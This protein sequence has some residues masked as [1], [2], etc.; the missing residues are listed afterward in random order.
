MNP[1]FSIVDRDGEKSLWVNDQNIWDLSEKELT[2]DVKKAI[3]NAY[4]IGASHMSKL[5]ASQYI[6]G[7]FSSK[8][9]DSPVEPNQEFESF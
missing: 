4:F 8:F 1:N 2:D 6:G 3:I 7:Q 5:V 9:I